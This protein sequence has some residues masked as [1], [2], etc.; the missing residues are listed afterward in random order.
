MDSKESKR[1]DT[2][3]NDQGSSIGGSKETIGQDVPQYTYDP[4]L[5]RRVR[6]KIDLA[7]IPLAA[8]I[9]LFCFIDRANIGNA[10]LAGLEED[11]G[12]SGYDFNSVNSIFFVSYIVFEI[13][14]NIACKVVGPG[15]WLPGLTIAFG[16]LTVA[17]GFVNNYDQ[18][19]GVRFLLGIFE[20]GVMPGL[21]YYLSRWYRHA[22]LTFRLS[23]YIVMAP[24]AGAFGGLLAS[25][26][27]RLPAIGSKVPSGSWRA[28]F[29]VEGIITLGIGLV[30]MV[31][32]TDRPD[33]ARFLT[34][35]EREV[36]VNRLK[37]ERVG[38]PQLLDKISK[39]KLLKGAINPV[40]AM[41]S[42]VFMFCSLSIQGLALFAP[43]LVRSIYPGVSL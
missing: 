30:T 6:W 5:E 11:L 38:N 20:A 33:T 18:L 1:R 22:E 16:G 35:E 15:Y 10:R 41:T 19:A 37:E 8:L 24:L 3:N 7:V 25:A 34:P 32:L 28:I 12:M 9:F 14:S 13:P 21:S 17:A 2:I 31:I 40:T 27:L 23:L 42:I 36:A 29:V 39:S 4:A 43:T 26:I